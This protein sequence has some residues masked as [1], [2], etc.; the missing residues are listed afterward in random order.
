[1]LIVKKILDDSVL[2]WNI[3][4]IA[5]NLSTL[6]TIIK[7]MVGLSVLIYTSIKIVKELNG[8]DTK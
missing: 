5:V 1:M 2:A 3:T 7:I 8:K 6:D 4:G